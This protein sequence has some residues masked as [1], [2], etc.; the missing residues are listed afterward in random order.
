MLTF[1]G[2]FLGMLWKKKSYG[3]CMQGGATSHTAKCSIL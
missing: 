3:Y 1:F 2:P